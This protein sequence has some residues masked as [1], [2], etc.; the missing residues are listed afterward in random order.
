MRIRIL[1]A[2]KMR[3]AELIVYGA[4]VKAEASGGGMRVKVPWV[5]INVGGKHHL[6]KIV[7]DI[8]VVDTAGGEVVASHS[9]EGT[10]R[11]GSAAAGA[12]FSGY[13]IPVSL[14]IVKNTPIG[15]AI[16][17]CIH[18]AVIKLCETI[19]ASFFRVKE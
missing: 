5:P 11:S 4:L 12:V 1:A 8:R 3:P 6:A 2:N 17:D 18:R 19:P 9:I 14:E 13:D 10:A 15:L 16:R 7:M